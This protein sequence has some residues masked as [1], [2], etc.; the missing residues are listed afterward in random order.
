MFE[1]VVVDDGDG[2]VCGGYSVCVFK[3]SMKPVWWV[4]LS[5]LGA[6]LKE[7]ILSIW[8]WFLLPS[9]KEV[10]ADTPHEV[11][12]LRLPAPPTLVRTH[13]GCGELAV[14]SSSE[15]D[16]RVCP[17]L[18]PVLLLSSSPRP[19]SWSSAVSRSRPPCASRLAS[20]DPSSHE[21]NYLRTEQL[22]V[23]LLY[24]KFL[25]LHKRHVK[26]CLASPLCLVSFPSFVLSRPLTHNNNNNNNKKPTTHMLQPHQAPPTLSSYTTSFTHLSLAH[27]VCWKCPAWVLSVCGPSFK[28]DLDNHLTSKSF[29]TT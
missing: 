17:Q 8:L 5:T 3:W 21:G 12:I 10:M 2:G 6:T 18:C 27:A 1:A 22:I 20:S 24:L 15:G 14:S 13:L 9:S 11:A 25:P 29:L 4:K 28:E 19:L 23:N 7:E 26:T 16:V